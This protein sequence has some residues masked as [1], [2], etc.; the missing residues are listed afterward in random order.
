MTGFRSL[1]WRLAALIGAVVVLAV[2]ATFVAIY[3]GTGTQ[4]RDQ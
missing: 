3:S 1:R 4:L 2:G